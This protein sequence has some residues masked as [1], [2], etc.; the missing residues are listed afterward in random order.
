[1]KITISALLAV[2]S[3]V[4]LGASGCAQPGVI[5]T[6][7]AETTAKKDAGTKPKKDAGKPVVSTDEDDDEDK[8]EDDVEPG[9]DEPEDDADE[10]TPVKPVDAGTSK[11]DTGVEKEPTEPVAKTDAGSK[12][13]AGETKT[14]PDAPVACPASYMCSDSSKSLADMG[15]DGTVTDP[16]GKPVTFSCAKGGQEVC[17]PKDAKK[18][19]PNFSKPFCIHVTITG[20]FDGYQCGQKCE[21]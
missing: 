19:C 5:E 14:E 7:P 4:L 12:K 3:V 17:D 15:L 10:E 6:H 13:D 16:D 21:P 1:M 18:S 20:L 11:K 2:S 9:E 8:G